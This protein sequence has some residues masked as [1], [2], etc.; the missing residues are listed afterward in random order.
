MSFVLDYKPLTDHVPAAAA[1]VPWDSDTFGL[2]VWDIDPGATPAA[3]L[4]VALAGFVA[5]RSQPHLLVTRLPID[6]VARHAAVTA[7]GFYPVEA[8]L[9][10]QVGLRFVTPIASRMPEGLLVRA[11]TPA[12]LALLTPLAMSAF[13]SD[14]FHLDP[15]LSKAAADLRYAQ[16]L[17]RALAAAEPV[18]V[19]AEV[20]SD[21]AC[22][23]FH[24]R[25]V[26]TKTVSL[27]LAAVDAPRRL[28]GA[29]P[30]LYQ[31]VLGRCR[32]AGFRFAKTRI[33]LANPDALDIYARLGFRLGPAQLTFHR[34]AAA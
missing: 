27:M 12:D 6:D 26:D 13:V 31:E 10:P 15:Y 14:R 25:A 3:A 33:S 7:C 5:S 9:E 28:V 8:T 24:V 21:L 19:L 2:D 18:W 4:Q 16:W 34:Y 20:G 17:E 22:G 11:G 1:R 32:E 30:V 29:G 23:F